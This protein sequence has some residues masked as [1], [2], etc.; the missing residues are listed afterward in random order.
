MIDRGGDFVCACALSAVGVKMCEF[1]SL[2]VCVRKFMCFETVLYLFGSTSQRLCG[3]SHIV[4]SVVSKKGLKLNNL[5]AEWP[6]IS[7]KGFMLLVS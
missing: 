3:H 7:C 6:N 4:F 1:A 2:Y 5:A